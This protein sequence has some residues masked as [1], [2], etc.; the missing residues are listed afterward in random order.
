METFFGWNENDVFYPTY[1][2]H[3]NNDNIR[4]V[5]SEAHASITAFNSFKEA[6]LRA[7]KLRHKNNQINQ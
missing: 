2:G 1:G 4:V 6:V 5:H 7:K 3:F